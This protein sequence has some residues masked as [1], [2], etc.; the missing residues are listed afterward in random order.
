V[1]EGVW[2]PAS[3]VVLLFGRVVRRAVN[4]VEGRGARGWSRCADERPPSAGVIGGQGGASG[5]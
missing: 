1:L 2:E 4:R 3:R 5:F